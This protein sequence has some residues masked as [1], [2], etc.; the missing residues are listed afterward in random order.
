MLSKILIGLIVVFLALVLALIF[1]MR[2][3]GPEKAREADRYNIPVIE[4]AMNNLSNWDY[5]DLKPYL[6]KHFVE[7]LASDENLQQD[8]D[9]I[10]ILGKV[11]SFNTPRHV[12]HKRYDHW[13]YGK[14]AV[15]LYSVSTK[16]EK[17]KGS[18][19]FKLNHCFENAEITFFQVVSRSLPTKSPALQ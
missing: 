6:S 9:E 11:L 2:Q 5:N 15:N 17:G 18:V 1:M 12:S 13:L 19:K 14:C 7:L 4:A 16:F 8:L 10:S 3:A